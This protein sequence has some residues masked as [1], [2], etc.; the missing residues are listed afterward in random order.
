MATPAQR[1][2]IGEGKISG[3]SSI[4]LGL[5]SLTGVICFKYPEWLTTPQFREVY[6]GE[7]MKI[8]LTATIIASFLF[9][10]I[11]FM[12]S[13]QKKWAMTGLLLCTGAI[14]FGGLQ[15]QGRPVEKNSWHLGVDWLLLDL[16]LMAAIFVPIEMVFPKN[17]QQ[18]KFHEEWRTDLLYF[19]I[20]H[21]FIQFLA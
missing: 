20:S 7:S 6:T 13:K 5:L 3:Y 11:S 19:V 18:S 17:R 10:L 9:A 4:F 12:L 14:V 15:V 16:L 21:L 1:L 8:V 2:G